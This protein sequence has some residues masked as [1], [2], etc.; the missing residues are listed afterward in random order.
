MRA[1]RPGTDIVPGGESVG[2]ELPGGRQQIG[3]LDRLVAGDARD[4]RF[5]GNIAL[6]E[7][8]DHRLAEPLLVV[9][10]IMRNAERLGDAARVGDVLAGATGADTMRRGAVVVE[11]QRHA[12][13]IVALALQ[14]AGND[15]R[16]DA[17]RHRD[18]DA[19]VFGPSR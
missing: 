8:I 10:H 6:G 9:Q 5:A 15:R 1:V 19:G 18:N 11:L 12:D 7:G 4:R 2:A 13:D 3:E 14:Q 17:A 16:I